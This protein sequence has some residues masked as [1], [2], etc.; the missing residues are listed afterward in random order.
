MTEII[1]WLDF[2]KTKNFFSVKNNVK[3]LGRKSQLGTAQ[4]RNT[5]CAGEDAEQR[6]GPHSLPAGVQR[7][8][9]TLEDS[10]VVSHKSKH[11]LTM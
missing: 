3:R 10:L 11:T 2:S 7:G 5:D 1:D 4:I 8:A 9:A 6:G